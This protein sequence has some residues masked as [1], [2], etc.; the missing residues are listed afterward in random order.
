MKNSNQKLSVIAMTFLSLFVF[1]CDKVKKQPDNTIMMAKKTPVEVAV[2]PK[3]AE[4]TIQVAL[5]LDT[6]NSM[7]GLIEQAKSR[8]WNIVNTLTTLKYEGKV[9]EIQISL[10][11]YGNSGLSADTGYIRQVTPL[12]TDLDLISEK[13]FALRTN[14]GSEYC[15]AVIEASKNQLK[16]DENKNSMKLI[17]IAGNEGFDQGNVNY[18]E[19]ISEVVNQ[20]IYVNTIFCGGK[21]EGINLHWE[22]GA[23]RGKGK[24]FNIDSNR[25]VRY[26]VTPYDDQISICN[27]KLN[28]TYIGYGRYGAEKM[29][30]QSAQD[31]NA[32]II[33]A[34]NQVERV[35]AKANKNVYKNSSW[36]LVDQ[37]EENEAVF[38][39]LEEKELPKELQGKTKE[40]KEQ[41]VKQ[42]REEREQIQKEI[43]DLAKKR[44]AYINE[45]K[46]K[47]PDVGDDLGKAIETSI[48][49]IALAN[50]FKQE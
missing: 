47:N 32:A 46:K 31:N 38:E 5:L 3:K 9:P 23:V 36:D 12:T 43:S 15:G 30:M 39:E 8:L 28:D 35:V 42:K 10:Y 14:G 40:E 24:Y 22:D 19:A 1:C 11:E 45:Q 13:L 29:E 2:T 6:S 20:N 27:S 7:D 16:W 48:L 50:G 25:K 18:K 33:S 17:Y 34:E 49:E 21:R 44:T 4:N 26:I 41:Y 37:Y